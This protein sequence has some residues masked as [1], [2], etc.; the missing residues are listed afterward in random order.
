M[1]IFALA[2]MISLLSEVH[3]WMEFGRE[4]TMDDK[5]LQRK[6]LVSPTNIIEN[7]E[8]GTDLRERQTQKFLDER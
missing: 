7:D 6:R 5:F 1:K 4:R 8:A 3:G 2:L